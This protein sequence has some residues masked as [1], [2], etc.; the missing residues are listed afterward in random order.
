[1]ALIAPHSDI[2]AVEDEVRAVSSALT[3]V[4]LRE[5]VSVQDVVTLLT[6]RRWEVVWFACHGSEAGIV[7]GPGA[8][9]DTSTLIQL[10]RNSGAEL[11]VLNTCDSAQMATYLCLQAGVAVVCTVAAV[12]DVTGATTGALLARNLARGMAVEA[13]YTQSVPGDVGLAQRYRL[14]DGRKSGGEGEVEETVPE[15]AGL[16][17]AQMIRRVADKQT[18]MA[19][20]LSTMDART[21]VIEHD[22]KQLMATVDE[23]RDKVGQIPPGYWALWAL[24]VLVIVGWMGT[25]IWLVQIH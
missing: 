5:R 16:N 19:E 2:A 25:L 8:T 12:G 10:V 15:Y 14:F 23:V 3:T 21:T 1:M 6:S 24:V 7:L 17:D 18:Q 13:A 9:L 4:T 11:V 22:I 20:R